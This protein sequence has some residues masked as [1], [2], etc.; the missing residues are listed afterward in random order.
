MTK[1][2]KSVLLGCALSSMLLIGAS[3]DYTAVASA[4]ASTPVVSDGLMRLR[5]V[6]KSTAGT[7]DEIYVGSGGDLGTAI[8]RVGTY[9]VSNGKDCYTTEGNTFSVTY[10][11]N[12]GM[13]TVE[14]SFS[15][16]ENT[17]SYTLAETAVTY[18]M[19]DG[20][21]VVV[22][23]IRDL[24]EA[25]LSLDT[26]TVDDDSVDITE[27]IV[28]T[29]Y[30]SY[31]I[32]LDSALEE[33][34]SVTVAGT[35][36]VSTPDTYNKEE[37]TKIDIGLGKAYDYKV[38]TDNDTAYLSEDE[39]DELTAY[40]YAIEQSTGDYYVASEAG[41]FDAVENAETIVFADDITLDNTVSISSTLTMDLGEYTLDADGNDYAIEVQGADITLQNGIIIADAA[42][43]YVATTSE[44]TAYSTIFDAPTTIAYAEDATATVNFIYEI[45]VDAD[46]GVSSDD[47]VFT[48]GEGT[49][50]SLP[51]ATYSGYS[52]NGWYVDNTYVTTDTIFTEDTTVVANWSKSV[53]TDTTTNTS[54][55]VADDDEEDETEDVVEDETEDETVDGTVVDAADTTTPAT[56]FA[57]LDTEDEAYEAV[58]TLYD[59]GVIN[60]VTEDS[61]EKDMDINRGMITT[62]LH[63]LESTPESFTDGSFD[64]VA[65]DTWYTDGVNWASSNGIVNGYTDGTFGAE[66]PITNQEMCVILMQYAEYLGAEIEVTSVDGVADVADWAQIAVAW[67]VENGIMTVD[68]DGN[69]DVTG[70]TTRGEACIMI[71]ALMELLAEEAEIAE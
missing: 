12:S 16:G 26:L 28:D 43:I 55:A 6:S 7:G 71:T 37:Y 45:S 34:D 1:L 69:L 25:G 61:F 46:G 52:F 50:D 30:R 11:V 23:G 8:Y 60:G 58:A 47:T 10:A 21:N 20:S 31:Y 9:D 19:A 15:N 13:D 67:A 63:R 38:V 39:F 65:E 66:N 24:Q 48:S 5:Y 62:M 29:T 68:A 3:V 54:T 57:D 64:D 36:S 51:T 33:G 42:A 17:A 53:R 41:I 70:V 14:A 2:W 59:L 4:D 56:P 40:D 35:F 22:L 49:L 44:I 27:V 32:Y 18:E